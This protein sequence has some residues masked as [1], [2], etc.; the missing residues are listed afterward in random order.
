MIMKIQRKISIQSYHKKQV[1]S[2]K[3]IQVPQKIDGIVD[4]GYQF[5]I[6][7]VQDCLRNGLT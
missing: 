7:H 4:E 1:Q 6:R 2:Y 5:E 3:R